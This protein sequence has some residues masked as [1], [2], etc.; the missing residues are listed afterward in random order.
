MDAFEHAKR[1][2][3]GK[4]KGKDSHNLLLQMDSLDKDDKDL[5]SSRIFLRAK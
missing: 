2:F 5:D 3:K 4:G 1:I